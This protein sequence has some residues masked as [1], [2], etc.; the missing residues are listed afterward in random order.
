MDFSLY[1]EL[2]NKLKA[3]A[4]IFLVDSREFVDEVEDDVSAIID[5]CDISSWH[6][7]IDGVTKDFSCLLSE[8]EAANRSQD[9]KK[10]IE[11]IAML[12]TA[13]AD[14]ESAY[15]NAVDCMESLVVSI[16]DDG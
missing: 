9:K 2:K 10:C 11:S 6:S 1:S 3:S 8:L 5:V 16:R 7:N 13:I 15:S 4:K 12:R 14:L